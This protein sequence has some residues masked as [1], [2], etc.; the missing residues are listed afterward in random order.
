MVHYNIQMIK[1]GIRPILLCFLFFYFFQSC[2]DNSHPFIPK[3]PQSFSENQYE[4]LQNKLLE[5]YES[6]DYFHIS[7]YLA[8]LQSPKKPIYENLKRAVKNDSSA[9]AK[10]FEVK[11]LAEQGFYR[12]VYKIDTNEFNKVL[13]LCLVQLGNNA[14]AK[15]RQNKIEETRLFLESREPLDSTQFDWNLIG[16]LKKINEDDQNLR[17]QMT[18]LNISDSEVD[19]LFKLQVQMDSINLLRVDSILTNIGYPTTELVGYDYDDVIVYVIHHQRDPYIRQEYLKRI[20]DYISLEKA[21][22]IEKRTQSII[23]GN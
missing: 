16:I 22:L 23:Q 15:F 7:F 13:D 10:I 11:Y 19:S 17:I 2:R 8:T 1:P 12:H 14:Y 20:Y 6:E 3:R 9:C 21:E 5:A 18:S 4:I